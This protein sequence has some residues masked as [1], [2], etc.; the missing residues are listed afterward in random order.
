[1]N[2]LER[3]SS[4]R[5]RR[6]ADRSQDGVSW[7]SP[8]SRRDDQQ[9][10]SGRTISK[11]DFEALALPHAPALYRTAYHLAGN[12]FEA[13][14]LTQETYLRAFR[15]I[16][17]FRGGD[18]RAWLFAILRHAFLDE[19]R[20][21]GRSPIVE[22]DVDESTDTLAASVPSA[23]LEALRNMPNEEVERA[24]AALPEDWRLIV[25]LA[26]VEGFSYREIASAMEI[27]L[28]T[29][30]SRLHRA[31]K[32]LYESMLAADRAN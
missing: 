14:D 21:R 13:E 10:V 11:G 32:R 7:A 23:E 6:L 31:R 19:C 2:W 17:G 22:F 18:L 29:V 5:A 1:V 16:G 12:A 28:G 20:R 24:L 27:P 8:D 25:M 4:L 9:A 3:A 30:M 26:D 15:G